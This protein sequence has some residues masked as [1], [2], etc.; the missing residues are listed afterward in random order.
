MS[1]Q[2][3]QRAAGLCD[4][5]VENAAALRI[6]VRHAGAV[7]ML[8]LG[9]EMPG[10]LEAGRRMAEVCMAGLGQVRIVP[11]DPEL[12]TGP[13]VMVVTD[14]PVAACMASQYAGWEIKGEDYFAM[15]SGPM[16]AAAGRE[17]LFESIGCQEEAENA[18]GVL[19]TGSFPPEPVCHSAHHAMPSSGTQISSR[20]RKKRRNGTRRLKMRCST[21]MSTQLW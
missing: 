20:F 2:L 10:G 12:S 8:D 14:Q 9:I 4:L 21:K 18:V 17:A 16:R 19:E 7:R 15:G 6:K 13:A 1:L 3:N 11:G 5:L